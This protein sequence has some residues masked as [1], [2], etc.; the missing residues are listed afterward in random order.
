MTEFTSVE[1]IVAGAERL[2]AAF[3]YH[4]TETP[5]IAQIFGVSPKAY[6]STAFLLAELGFDGIDINMG[7]PDKNV[8]K[9]GGGA[10]LILQP[11]HAQQII[12]TTKQ[13]IQDWYEGRKIHTVGLPDP[14]VTRMQ[15]LRERSRGQKPVKKHILPV[16]VK[17]RIGYDTPVTQDWI[18]TLIEAQP[19]AISLHGRTLKQMYTGHADWEEIAQAA[20]LT[21]SAGIPL[22]GNGDILSMSQAQE[23]IT[24]YQ[25][26]GALVGRATLGNPWFFSSSAREQTKEDRFQAIRD[27][28]TLFERYLPDSDFLSLRKHIGWYCKGFPFASTVRVAL[29]QTRT[30]A[31]VEEVL[32]LY[33]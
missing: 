1:G 19:A 12:T 23:K 31:E 30:R 20:T 29:M 8:T 2:L 28:C 16:S 11:K 24:T 26:D 32:R 4:D 25:T 6:Y 9:R 27:H 17:T 14:I 18:Q 22:L 15:E 3:V 13:A 33:V 21:Q 5:T 10:A 7:C